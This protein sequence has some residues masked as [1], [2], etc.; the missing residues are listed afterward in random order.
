[1]AKKQSS[2]T[3]RPKKPNVKEEW[4]HPTKQRRRLRAGMFP[5]AVKNLPK[6]LRDKKGTD[7]S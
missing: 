1:M 6:R 2:I 5:K 7:D 3:A 4:K